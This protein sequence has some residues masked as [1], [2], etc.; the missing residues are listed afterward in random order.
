VSVGQVDLDVILADVWI[1]PGEN[2]F[3]G[4]QENHILIDH[5]EAI[6]L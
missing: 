4:R 1:Y 5:K 6:S 2:V 3:L